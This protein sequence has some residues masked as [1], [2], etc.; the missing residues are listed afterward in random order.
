MSLAFRTL[1]REIISV[2]RE[3]G[4]AITSKDG[5][6]FICVEP[7]DFPMNFSLT[8]FA[9]ELAKRMERVS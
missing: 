4:F 8:T 3:N 9:K 5:E 1:E 7:F 6:N 2:L